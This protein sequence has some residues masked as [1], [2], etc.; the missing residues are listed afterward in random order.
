MDDQIKTLRDRALIAALDTINNHLDQ[1]GDMP[2]SS[3]VERLIFTALVL[4]AKTAQR[5][6]TSVHFLEP[7]TSPPDLLEASTRM[8]V[9]PQLHPGHTGFDFAVY[10][11]DH[12]PRYLPEAGW[13]R[14]IVE[15]DTGP[16]LPLDA[17]VSRAEAAESRMILTHGQIEAD[18]W[19]V[20]S[21]IF[22]WASWSFG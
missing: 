12:R 22:D 17:N 18:A 14:L 6:H 1:S 15:T 16:S 3:D 21:R 8:Y 20:A 10:A 4:V 5:E 7:N 9:S 13:R 19:L 11:Y 2:G